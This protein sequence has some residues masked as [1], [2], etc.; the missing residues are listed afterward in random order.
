MGRKSALTSDGVP[1]WMVTPAARSG[2]AVTDSTALQVATVLACVRVIAQGMA[3]VPL[4][5]HRRGA[6]GGS[7]VADD[8]PLHWLLYRK[9]N[10]WQTAYELRSIMS[11]YREMTGNA[12]AYLNRGVDG[13]ILEIIPINPRHVSVEQGRDWRLTYRVTLATGEHV[14]LGQD[15]VWH[16]R[17][18]Q[19]DA[20]VGLDIIKVA[21][22]AIGL[23]IATEQSHADM[24]RNGLQTSGVYSVD[25]KLPPD[26]HKELVTFLKNQASGDNRFN[27]IILDMDAKFLA[28]SMSGVDAQHIE[29]RK[30]QIEE[31]CRAFGVLPIMIGYADKTA[32]Y[33]SAE[34]MFIA[35]DV[36]CL[37]PRC[38]A[39]EQSIDVQL[40]GV[41]DRD[42]THFAKHNLSGLLRGA[43]K[44]RGEYY[45]KM[46]SVGAMSP[47]DI[48]ALEDMNPYP[49]G[50]EYRV[51]L[52]MVPP[53][54]PPADPATTPDA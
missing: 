10:S 13:R 8:H 21:R 47:N 40:L 45:A 15:D 35:H 37:A 50:D 4:K 25:G 54:T 2:V 17:G 23:A 43:V 31:Q 27:P 41:P 34:Q 52:N 51:P 42:T 12:V 22:E 29:T 16:E 7:E 5:I 39:R 33:A 3:Q 6:G 49:G 19:W 44:D 30:H 46:Y 36:H 18:L 48:R 14:V 38:E 26:K 32:T 9:P 11:V 1:A 53:G 24:H 28:R 20:T